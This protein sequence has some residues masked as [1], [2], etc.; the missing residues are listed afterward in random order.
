ME[1]V[2][3]ADKVREFC[4]QFAEVISGYTIP[5]GE[6]QADERWYIR[7]Y[8]G[9]RHRSRSQ[10]V[11]ASDGF[12]GAMSS[13]S[14]SVVARLEK[15][16]DEIAK[17]GGSIRV[18]CEAV[19]S[20]RIHKDSVHILAGEAAIDA[21]DGDGFSVSKSLVD[22]LKDS[23]S[24]TLRL[25]EKNLEIV[26]KVLSLS[27]AASNIAKTVGEIQGYQ[28]AG[29]FEPRQ[30]EQDPMKVAMANVVETRMGSMFDAFMRKMEGG[31][32]GE[33]WEAFASRMERGEVTPEE[34]AKALKAFKAAR[35]ADA[36]RASESNKG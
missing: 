34:F 16:I 5:E 14:V 19:F 25:M 22:A 17:E 20:D 32:G 7:I 29:G 31:K 1:H 24:F 35:D 10:R 13:D 23:Q 4:R 2:E 8:T 33:S 30:I 9:A 11:A 36:R 28:A 21:D 18:W 15:Q 6:E 12:R 3:N 26:N 27:D